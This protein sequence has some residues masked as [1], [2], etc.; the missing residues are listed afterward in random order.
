MEIIKK[1]IMWELLWLYLM[2]FRFMILYRIDIWNMIYFWELIN[3][4][5]K[6]VNEFFY[7]LNL[8]MEMINYFYM[9]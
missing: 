2:E 8:I 6:L 9:N 3:V 5:N 1:K 7:V 4:C